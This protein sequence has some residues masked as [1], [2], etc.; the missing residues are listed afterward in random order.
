MDWTIPAL[1]IVIVICAIYL[2]LH[3]YR[4]S[5]RP[6]DTVGESTAEGID[7]N[8]VPIRQGTVPA[9][10][11]SWLGENRERHRPDRESTLPQEHL[12]R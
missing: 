10:E 8:G 2:A 1:V 4:P 7:Q 11:R 12:Q 9:E 5:N 6:A 3:R